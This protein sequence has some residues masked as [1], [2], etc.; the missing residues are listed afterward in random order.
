[1]NHE[2]H[3]RRQALPDQQGDHGGRYAVAIDVEDVE[4]D[5]LGVAANV[6]RTVPVLFPGR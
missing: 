6:A 5:V 4:R 3:R 1:M 2:P